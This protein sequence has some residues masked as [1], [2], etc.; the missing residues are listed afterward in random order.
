VRHVTRARGEDG[1]TCRTP[2]CD[3]E[4]YSADGEVGPYDWARQEALALANPDNDD[5]Q[6][7][8]RYGREQ[9]RASRPTETPSHE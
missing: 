4:C 6:Q 8:T 2:A 5:V 9:L 3:W 7:M 1:W